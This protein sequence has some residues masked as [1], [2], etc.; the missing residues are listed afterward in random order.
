MAAA[1]SAT[2]TLAL[3]G[4]VSGALAWLVAIVLGRFGILAASD[5]GGVQLGPVTL[6]PGVAFG[7]ILGWYLVKRGRLAA[8]RFV[9][10]VIASAVSYLLAYHVAYTIGALMRFDTVL[11]LAADGIVAG[12]CGSVLLALLT[13]ALLRAKAH[14]LWLSVA[15]GGGAG[16]LLP[17]AAMGD[18]G[19]IALGPLVFFVLWQGAYAASLAPAID[20]APA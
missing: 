10:F 19:G 13:M 6:A 8:G 12:L 11:A 1:S 14:A 15:I 5:V 9:A 18:W 3:L 7:V 4:A 16:V 17:L 20:G 2:G